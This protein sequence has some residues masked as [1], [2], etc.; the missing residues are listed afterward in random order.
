MDISGLV[1]KK[2]YSLK[3]TLNNFYNIYDVKIVKQAGDQTFPD[4]SC[5]AIITE[6]LPY[7]KFLIEVDSVKDKA[8]NIIG[9]QNKV[10]FVFYGKK[11]LEKPQI[12]LRRQ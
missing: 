5:V 3:D 11:N 8:G 1:E 7:R 12:N 4:T 2:N 6:R 10:T 9:E